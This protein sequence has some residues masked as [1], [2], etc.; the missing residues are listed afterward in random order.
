M[1]VGFFIGIRASFT[2]EAQD[3]AEAFLGAI[4]SELLRLCLPPYD[5]PTE[6]PQVYEGSL[7][8]RSALDH[9]SARLIVELS[10]RAV[11][12]QLSPQMQLLT[13]NPYRVAYVPRDINPPVETGFQDQIAGDLYP[14]WCGAAGRLHKELV[15]CA[16]LIGVP[17]GTQGLD[18]E[19]ARRINEFEP[20]ADNEKVEAELADLRTTWL[21]LHEA[22]RLSVRTGVAL[23]LAG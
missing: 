23:C 18:D 19:I 7:F 12:A 11:A 9:D 2:E 1:S 17:L 3:S 20:L 8:G 14:I 6:L 21:T 22:A 4:N 5:E 10:R 13:V 15:S 16:S